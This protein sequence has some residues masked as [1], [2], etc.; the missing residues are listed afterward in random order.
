[1]ASTVNPRTSRVGGTLTG[2][3]DYE[4]DYKLIDVVHS[5]RAP[6]PIGVSTNATGP[7]GWPTNDFRVRF[8]TE[9]TPNANGVYTLIHNGGQGSHRF[10]GPSI[11]VVNQSFEQGRWTKQIRIQ[12]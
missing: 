3:H 11:Q 2:P 10:L 7:T 5:A 6:E 8:L 4:R 9:Q 12:A 1:M